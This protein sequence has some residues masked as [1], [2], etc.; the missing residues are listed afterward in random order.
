MVLRAGAVR[1]QFLLIRNIR[2]FGLSGPSPRLRNGRPA[3]QRCRTGA[4]YGRRRGGGR[5]PS[6][7]GGGL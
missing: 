6:G 3:A 2:S 4:G 1:E 5:G 7:R